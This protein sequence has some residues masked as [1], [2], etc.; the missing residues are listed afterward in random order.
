M[1]AG[2]ARLRAG[3]AD[4]THVPGAVM[5]SGETEEPIDAVIAWVDGSDPNHAARR[6]AA[7]KSSHAFNAPKDALA[8]TRFSDSGEIYYCIASILKYA[9]FVRRIYIVC[10]QQQPP[11]MDAFADAG[12]CGPDRIV[13]VDHRTIFRGYESSL[14]TFNSRTIETMIWRVPDLSNLFIYF[15]DDFFINRP[16]AISEFIGADGRAIIHGQSHIVWPWALKYY[17]REKIYRMLGKSQSPRFTAAQVRAAQILDLRRYLT[18]DHTPHLLSIDIFEEFFSAHPD[19]LLD[20]ISYQF[21]NISQFRPA[22]LWNHIALITDRARLEPIQPSAF[23][24]PG[25][26]QAAA[27]NM[28]SRDAT[29]FGCIQSFDL[30]SAAERA[31]IRRNMANKFSGYMPS[32]IASALE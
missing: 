3:P 1:M 27:L 5:T 21:R 11:L 9:P 20:Q 2:P 31:R 16:L 15:N 29:A 23:L 6:A 32:V 19:I 25:R 8:K 28:I 7:L 12:L 13:A 14:P 10:D 18:I 24:H 30:F 4:R 17:V 22:A 26:D